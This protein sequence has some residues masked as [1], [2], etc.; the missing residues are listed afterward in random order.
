[1]GASGVDLRDGTRYTL[2]DNGDINTYK[3]AGKPDDS[4]IDQY[5]FLPALGYCYEG[6][7]LSSSV[8]RTGSY[9]LRSPHPEYSPD[10]ACDFLFH[11][12]NISVGRTARNIG[13]VLSSRFFK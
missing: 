1:M 10:Y 8:G 2:S 5:F 7:L 6:N 3:T 13:Y 12:T 9:W 4:V 11:S